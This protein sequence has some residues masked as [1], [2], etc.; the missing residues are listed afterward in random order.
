MPSTIDRTQ[1]PSGGSLVSADIR[2]GVTNAA[3]NDIEALQSR[4]DALEST[5][6]TANEKAAMTAANSPSNVN[7]FA[8]I[9]DVGGGTGGGIA[10]GTPFVVGELLEVSSDA[11]DGVA[12]SASLLPVNLPTINRTDMPGG[13]LQFAVVTTLPA[14]PDPNTIYFVT[15]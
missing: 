5:T 10:K 6:P 4:A 13:T 7:A 8:T 14:S 11:G 3:A 2:N 9:A 1:P 15:T 12:R